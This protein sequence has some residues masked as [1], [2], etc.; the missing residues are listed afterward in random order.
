M[1]H[2]LGLEGR[3]E[4]FAQKCGIHNTDPRYYR[5]KYLG[6][7][8]VLS[9]LASFGVFSGWPLS[10]AEL[11]QGLKFLAVAVICIVLL[12]YRLIPIAAMFAIAAFR[13]VVGAILYHRWEGFVLGLIVG[14]VAAALVL[15]RLWFR[16]DYSI[17]YEFKPYSVCECIIDVLAFLLML[18]LLHKLAA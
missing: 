2:P 14:A 13:F 12:P 7:L 18:G 5:D 17:P 16:G 9:M 1:R 15:G 6:T 3:V 8:F 10:H 11:L 4:Y